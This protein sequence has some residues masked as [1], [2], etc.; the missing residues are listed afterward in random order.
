MNI[1]EIEKVKISEMIKTLTQLQKK[2]CDLDVYDYHT[3]SQIEMIAAF[4]DKG[5][6]AGRFIEPSHVVIE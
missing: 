1:Q 3:E 2:H 6:E 4:D 5:R